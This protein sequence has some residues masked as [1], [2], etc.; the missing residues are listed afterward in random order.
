VGRL[1][2]HAALSFGIE[3][4]YLVLVDKPTG[5]QPG[6][7]TGWVAIRASGSFNV[8]GE[9]VLATLLLLVGFVAV[10][11]PTPADSAGTCPARVAVLGANMSAGGRFEVQRALAV[12]PHTRQLDE[13]LSDEREQAHGLVPPGLLGVV[14]ISSGLL[15]PRPAGSGLTVRLNRNITLHTAQTY[16]NALLTAGITSATVGVAA[17]TVGV[18]AP[19]AQ[20]ALGT[21]A[22]LGLLRAARAACVTVTPQRRDLAI[23]EVVL[24]GELAQ[25]IGRQTAPSLMFALKSDVVSHRL[26]TPSALQAL[27]VRDDTASGVTVPR[28]GRAAIVAFLHDLVASG[29]YAGVAHA[30][31]SARAVGALQVTV[32]LVRAARGGTS[33]VHAPVQAGVWHGTVVS[34]AATG[35]AA[36]VGGAVYDVGLAPASRV[37][38]NGRRSS[39]AA[40]QPGDT[41]TVTTNGA[42]LATLLRAAGSAA[43]AS[44][45]ATTATTE[46][47]GVIAV[48]AALLVLVLLLLP[49]L[50]GLLRRRRARQTGTGVAGSD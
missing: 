37:Y 2:Q 4:V 49:V 27:V 26:L 13:T 21:T 42:G 44:P 39:I 43:P 31:P 34:V 33:A 45:A 29:A 5:R 22:L 9:M 7:Y 3:P 50:V 36:R 19:T 1:L 14:A 16:A 20:Q 11:L 10:G 35:V 25:Q 24:T 28:H 12:G 23:R 6:R 32:R 46:T 30:H 8:C 38:R 40:L 41:I 15:Q 48:L 17:A 18:A 47:A